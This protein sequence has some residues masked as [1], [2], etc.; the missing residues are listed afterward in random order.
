MSRSGTVRRLTLSGAMFLVS[1]L[2]LACSG[3]AAPA[4]NGNG[5]GKPFAPE[6]PAAT[7]GPA[8]PAP[9]ATAVS[10][11]D[12][13]ASN[14]GQYI[15]RSGSLELEV[16]DVDAAATQAR[17]LV[18]AG[19][20]YVSASDE[21]TKNERH[22]ATITYRIPVDRWQDT[23]TA[24]RA[25]GTR[26]VTE[27]TQ[28]DEVTSQVVDLGAR[29]DNLR[30]AEA[31]IRDIMTRA[32]TIDD[33]LAVQTRLQSVQEEIER[34]VAQQ[35]DLTGRAALA[36][37]AVTWETPVVDV[38]AVQEVQS[39]WNLSHEIDH[40]LAQTVTAGQALASFLIWL[41]IVGVPVFGPMILIALFV[42]WIVRRYQRRH[43][44][45][46]YAGWGTGPAGYAQSAPAGWYPPA[47]DMPGYPAAGAPVA[48][49]PPDELE[50][51]DDGEQEGQNRPPE[52]G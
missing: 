47:P 5:N 29:I 10:G 35:Q 1:V 32:G 49:A 11:S 21:S 8:R 9:G 16:T 51:E 26:V 41:L 17:G 12:G 45:P 43:P 24:L 40:A 18:T 6:V 31:S 37:L 3:S 48:G 20:G 19:G 52:A 34:L 38:P 36:T 13:S 15:V 25:I 42:I 2:F 23:I 28:A 50:D 27:N 7:A 30:T 39:G 22:V 33:V 44:R 46:M 14:P 4:G